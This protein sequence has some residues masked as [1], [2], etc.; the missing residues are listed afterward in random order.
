METNKPADGAVKPDFLMEVPKSRNPS[1][2]KL[3]IG[4]KD[5]DEATYLAAAKLIDA[6]KD[7]EATKFLLKQLRVSGCSAEEICGNFIALRSAS[8]LML[9]ILRPVEGELKKN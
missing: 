4:I 7:T 9:Q 3:V 6:G 1:D 8:Q 2:E 5:L